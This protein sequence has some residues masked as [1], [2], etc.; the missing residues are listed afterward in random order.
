MEE[1]LAILL[2]LLGEFI[3]Q[4]VIDALGEIIWSIAKRLLGRPDRS[5][6]LSVIVLFLSG[7]LVAA[8][9]LVIWP[10]CFFR[11]GAIPG[12]SLIASPLLAGLVM[13][14]YGNYRRENNR[15][16]TK[17]ATFGGGAALAFGFAL[18]RF[19]WAR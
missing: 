4:L 6:S 17:I 13:R 5:Y 19:I 16:T 2:Q 14:L 10:E 7:C 12:L 3:L 8:L 9:S 1:I 18:V 11:P 15:L